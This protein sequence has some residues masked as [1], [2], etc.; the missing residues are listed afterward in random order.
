[1]KET[2][3]KQ[4]V[5][6]S[7]QG[8]YA[9]KVAIASKRCKTELAMSNIDK[10]VA[11]A[12]PTTEFMQE[13]FDQGNAFEDTLIATVQA[14][15]RRRSA[16]IDCFSGRDMEDIMED[17]V[18]ASQGAFV[19]TFEGDRE[20][21]SR[22]LRGNA[23]A[24]ILANP[25]TVRFVMNGRLNATPDMTKIG[26]PDFIIRDGD[27]DN[28]RPAWVGVDAKLHKAVKDHK[29]NT[30]DY[31]NLTDIIAGKTLSG[32]IPKT[33]RVPQEDALQ[34]VH[35]REMLSAH[36][37]GRVDERYGYVIG[38]S[39]DGL[40]LV[41]VRQDLTAKC[42]THNKESAEDTY[43]RG[44]AEARKILTT[45]VGNSRIPK[46]RKNAL[47]TDCQFRDICKDKWK[48]SDELTQLA[49]VTKIR[50]EKIEAAGIKSIKDLAHTP[51]AQAEELGIKPEWIDTARVFDS[52]RESGKD[53]AYR[54]RG[55]SFKIDLRPV[56]DFADMENSVSIGDSLLDPNA[57]MVV[58]QWGVHSV[59]YETTDAGEV[60]AKNEDVKHVQFDSFRHTA[61]AERKVFAD[62]WAYTQERI[63]EAINTHGSADAYGMYVWSGAEARIL[64]HLAKKH[65]GKVGVPSIG[66]VEAFIE[67][68]V[69]DQLE[70]AKQ[71]VFPAASYSIKDI[72]KHI[73]FEWPMADASGA[74]STLWYDHAVNAQPKSERDN[75]IA[76]IRDYN[77]ADTQAQVEIQ[78]RFIRVAR[79][80]KDNEFK[81]V[82]RLD[83]FYEG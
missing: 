7:P 48:K 20:G 25:G 26:E 17:V 41:A 76:K 64:R 33:G 9:A 63:E 52:A 54:A 58:Y 45:A 68:H 65:A 10:Y 51:I 46:P 71:L 40:G 12:L 83:K 32:Q 66:E 47:C 70:T 1:M 21:N 24:A 15:A 11:Q 73:G 3:K 22:E 34:L 23:T 82:S 35:Y 80:L 61:H 29:S 69:I 5:K 38:K 43:F 16:V 36:G 79:S 39:I 50:A 75:W 42:Y 28:G 4:Q 8:G 62:F 19:V 31:V 57:E 81:S 14:T 55:E 13:L 6:I 77:R 78:K 30:L 56:A 27:Q 37:F 59:N 53:Y 44:F 72:A 18:E 49:G 74:N 67:N 2:T 60:S